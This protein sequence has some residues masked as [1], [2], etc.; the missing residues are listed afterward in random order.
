MI[1]ILEQIS[2]FFDV[3]QPKVELGQPH[4][5]VTFISELWPV[6]DI[7]LTHFGDVPTVTEPLCKC[8]NSF[9]RSYGA[10]FI[11]LL[12]QL[13]DR[14]VNAFEAT[15]QSCYLWVSFKLVR[16]YALD[17]G[18]SAA[19]CFQLVQRLSQSMFSK[20]QKVD[21]IPDVIEE[22]YRMMTAY[23]DKA[24]LLLV[25]DEMLNT[26]FQAGLVSL[27]IHEK[28]ALGAVL[29]FFTNLLDRPEVVGLYSEYGN[30]LMAVLF[31]GLVDYYHHDSIQDVAMLLKSLAELLPSESIQWMINVVNTVPQEYMSVNFKNDFIA[32]WTR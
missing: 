3:I 15:G 6:L 24:P 18:D 27:T 21:D 16:E 14:I 2:V 29:V 20:L 25:Q 23:L 5:C 22:Y 4:P 10:H 11:P 12:P 8:F 7:T 1:D 13:M 17:K 32:N 28:H 31:N 9:I 30:Q 19:P 26:V